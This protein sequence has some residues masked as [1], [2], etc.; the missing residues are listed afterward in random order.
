VIRLLV[1]DDHAIVRR[2]LREILGEAHDFTV[3]G[4][5][6]TREEVLA[7][8]GER[9]WDVLILD[10]SL[11]G[12]SGIDLLAEVKHRRPDLPVLILTVHPEDQYALRALRAGAA[13]YLTKESAPEQ[14]VEAVRKVVRGG[15]YVS[16]TVAERLAFN[17][18]PDAGRPPHE[19]LSDREYEVL[20][21]LASGKTVSEVAAELSL[22]VKTV[23]TYR[24]RV[25]EK[26]GMRT[27]AELTHYAI[28]NRLVD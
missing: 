5:A 8:I 22:S 4:E 16:P 19:A 26:M 13:G 17:L 12:C 3:A 15:R 14:L 25:L 28:K 6:A 23:S 9:A 11:P 7:R 10:L 24:T 2:G 21:M 20:R 18:G 1:A 27:N